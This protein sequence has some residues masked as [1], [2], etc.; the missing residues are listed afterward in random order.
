MAADLG[1]VAHT[2]ECDADEFATQR[3]GNA[4]AQGRLTDTR[5]T[6][7]HHHSTGA[8][9]A[10]NLQTALCTPGSHRQVFDDAVLD[11]VQPV[12]IGV[13]DLACGLEVGR[14]L[15]PG[16]PRQV[17][18]GVQPGA[19]PAA[20]GALVAGA[21]QLPD[22]AQRGLADLVRQV[23]RLD[24]GPVI[25]GALGF[26]LAQL[27]A[28]RVE[29]LAQQELFLLLFHALADVFG[30]LVVDL[31]FGQ[32]VAGPVDQRRQPFG[33]IFGLQQLALLHVG[34][35]R[36]VTG[37]VG[38]GRGVDQLVDHVDELPGLA[39]LQ[40]CQQQLLVFACELADVVTGFGIGDLGHLDPQRSPWPAGAGA[41]VGPPLTTHDRR[42]AAAGYPADLHD[43]R[44]HAV[45]RVAVLEPGRDQQCA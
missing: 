45:R 30:D 26:P 40:H 43:R 16:V 27:L 10:D 28:D 13:E 38:Q 18:H 22:L 4:L 5:R 37:H 34:Q 31:D 19:D 9:T 2:T 11:V 39:A 14:V 7:Q 1:L 25:V 15:G 41:D 42:G 32:L 29:L 6:G 3:S 21:F 12:V 23:G 33:D 17:E 24:T 36:R 44:E 35:I 8:A 20:F